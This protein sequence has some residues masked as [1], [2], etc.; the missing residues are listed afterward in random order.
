MALELKPTKHGH[1]A[2]C[3]QIP[4]KAARSGLR[5]HRLSSINKNNRPAAPP[6]SRRARQHALP[7]CFWTPL[8]ESEVG[9]LIYIKRFCCVAEITATPPEKQAR[10]EMN[11]A[12]FGVDV[13]VRH[14]C[15]LR[16][17]TGVSGTASRKDPRLGPASPARPPPRAP[18]ACL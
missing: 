15:P 2:M 8:A 7:T 1:H 13:A 3:G 10:N 5:P 18:L 16:M 4:K 11:A 6:T 14:I 12:V 9:Q 17:A